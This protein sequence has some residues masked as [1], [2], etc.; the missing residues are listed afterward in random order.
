MLY[1]PLILLP[2]IKVNLQ[3]DQNNLKINLHYFLG[4]NQRPST[5]QNYNKYQVLLVLM[6]CQRVKLYNRWKK[7]KDRQVLCIRL[8]GCILLG[9]EWMKDGA[10]VFIW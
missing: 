2:L 7:E 4:G 10:L 8:C 6:N 9:M 1:D 3:G 5:E